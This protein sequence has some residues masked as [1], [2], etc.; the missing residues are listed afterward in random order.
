MKNWS[1]QSLNREIKKHSVKSGLK[2]IFDSSSYMHDILA[3]FI[4]TLPSSIIMIRTL[5]NKEKRTKLRKSDLEHEIS[6]RTFLLIDLRKERCNPEFLVLLNIMKAWQWAALCRE[7]LD[8]GYRAPERV[9][10]FQNLEERK[11][12]SASM[13]CLTARPVWW[14]WLLT[15]T[16]NPHMCFY[17]RLYSIN[18]HR[19]WLQHKHGQWIFQSSKAIV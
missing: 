8:L 11:S 6:S 16:K 2:W 13:L 14:L 17:P 19:E 7:A 18:L 9:G 4:W 1:F 15:T 12:K 5:A 10:L 3:L